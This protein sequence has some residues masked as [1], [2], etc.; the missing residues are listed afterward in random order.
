M[1]EMS[2]MFLAAA[3]TVA[4]SVPASA[5]K[6]NSNA[7]GDVFFELVGQSSLPSSPP[8]SPSSYRVT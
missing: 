6:K 1:K 7:V 4:A 2:F 5:Q 3:V 8:S